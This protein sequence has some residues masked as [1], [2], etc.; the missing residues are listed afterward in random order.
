METKNDNNNETQEGSHFSI[1]VDDNA[2][3]TVVSYKTDGKYPNEFT[4]RWDKI[5]DELVA[6]LQAGGKYSELLE[7]DFNRQELIPDG[8]DVDAVK[9][10][11]LDNVILK[12]TGAFLSFGRL[13]HFP[14]IREISEA[15]GIPYEDFMRLTPSLVNMF[16]RLYRKNGSEFSKN[17]QD[18]WKREYEKDL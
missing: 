8:T 6:K 5:V 12:G 10:M 15:T 4:E 2:F 9:R 7:Y 13:R 18:D 3:G 14:S 11:L 17:Y 1:R 16:V